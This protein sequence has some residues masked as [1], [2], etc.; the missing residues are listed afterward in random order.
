MFG[1]GVKCEAS[2][3]ADVVELGAR[4][5]VTGGLREFLLSVGDKFKRVE[6]V[7]SNR[8]ACRVS[9][10]LNNFPHHDTGEGSN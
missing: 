9:P 6:R 5:Q 1:K 8:H 3:S 10:G 7:L 4:S 2:H